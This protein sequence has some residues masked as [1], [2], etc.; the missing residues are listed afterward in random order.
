MSPKATAGTPAAQ[1]VSRSDKAAVKPA[2]AWWPRSA[3]RR[4]RTESPP[5]LLCIADHDTDRF[6][7]EGPMTDAE[8][9]IREVIAA[10]RA[11]RDISCRVMSGTADE[12][13]TSWSRSHGGT[14][15]PSGSIVNPET[16]VRSTGQ[17]G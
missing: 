5:F 12:A 3:P 10:R 7:L 16:A 6:T 8:A 17:S 14:R 2:A 13:A 1:I 15:W 4:R 9:W 11:G